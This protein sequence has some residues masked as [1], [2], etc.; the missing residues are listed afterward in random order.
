MTYERGAGA[1][2][3]QLEGAD[4]PRM[5][6]CYANDLFQPSVERATHRDIGVCFVA[7]N[8]HPDYDTIARFRRENFAAVR[9]A[10]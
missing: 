10:S 3:A 2:I 6:Y 8:R 5:I 7:A 9:R 1:L 4:H